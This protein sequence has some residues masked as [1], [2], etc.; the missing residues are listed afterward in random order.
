[1]FFRNRMIEGRRRVFVSAMSNNN[2][3]IVPMIDRLTIVHVMSIDLVSA[4]AI[5]R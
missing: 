5:H 2:K 1:M 3:S 4:G